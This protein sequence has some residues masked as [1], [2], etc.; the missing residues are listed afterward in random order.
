MNSDVTLA[1]CAFTTNQANRGGAIA[2]EQS[3]PVLANCRLAG[4]RSFSRLSHPGYGGAALILGGADCQPLFVN[5]T[6]VANSASYRGGA[7]HSWGQP[8]FV[9]CAFVANDG[10]AYAGAIDQLPALPVS[11]TNS[12][13]WG[14]VATNWSQICTDPNMAEVTHSCVQDGWPG[15]SNID[16]DPMFIDADGLDNV[17]GTD[18]DD[19]RLMGGSPCLD[20]A[21][22]D[23]LPPDLLD[24][25]GDGDLDEWIPFDLDGTPRIVDDIVDMGP[26]EGPNPGL[27]DR[28]RSR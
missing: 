26:Y 9:N 2:V 27:H 4:N 22:N 18:D 24:L 14:N 11:V 8:E 1:R 12:V 5:C 6:F 15:E 19:L 17:Y 21:L 10:H 7:I 28:R 25:D 23:A 16:S 3:N 20:A 13:I